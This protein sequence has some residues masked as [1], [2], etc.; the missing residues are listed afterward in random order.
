MGGAAYA[1]AVGDARLPLPLAGG[2]DDFGNRLTSFG[3]LGV[4]LLRGLQLAWGACGGHRWLLF[5][6]VL[7]YVAIRYG[8][9]A[10]WRRCEP[11]TSVVAAFRSRPT[12]DCVF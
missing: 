8:V 4:V 11:V 5:L 3:D 7:V 6:G 10:S 2:I 9:T 12:V 1:A